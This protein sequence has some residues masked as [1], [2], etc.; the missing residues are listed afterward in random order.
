MTDAKIEGAYL[1]NP[2][3]KKA[4]VPIEYTKEQVEEYIKCANDCRYF[5]EEYV[6]IVHIDKGL[7]PFNMYPF[8]QKMVDAFTNER[9]VINKLPRQSGKSTTVTAYML[10]RVL[11][12]DNQN[13]AI[14]ANKGAL[15]RDLLSKVTMAYEHLPKWLQQGVLLWNRGNVELENGSKIVAAATSGSAIRGGSYNLIFLDEFAFVDNNLAEQFFASVYPT[16]SSGQTSQVI[17]V[18][19]PNGLN[20]FY[21][22]W[23]DA[24]EER[25]SYFPIEVQWQEVPGRDEKWKKETIANTSEEQFR[26]EFECE[27]IGSTNTLIAA[28]KL[29]TMAWHTPAEQHG[30][31]DIHK[32]PEHNHTYVVMVDT[33]RGL[34]LDYSASVVIDVSAMPYRVVAKFRHNNMSPLVYPST[35]ANIA[36]NYNDAFVLV[37]LNDIGQQVADILHFE[38][39]YENI[40][41]T[42]LHGR[43]GQQLGGGFGKQTQMGVKTT[44]QV[45]GIGCS[46]LKDLVEADKLIIEDFEIIGELASFVQRGSSYE[47]EPGQNDD[48]AMCLV[49][50]GWLANQAYFKEIT[51]IDIRQKIYNQKMEAMEDDILP[52]GIVEDGSEEVIVDNTGQRWTQADLPPQ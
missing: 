39:E 50:F 25:S 34:G 9:F 3:L 15:A 37:E 17:I 26:Q 11:F 52:F 41:A 47:A 33:S 45:K 16:I 49:L 44:K 19:T 5:I 8:Q 1:G 2:N 23:V 18:S 43:A 38:L 21:K 20:H 30:A 31:L 40:L 42:S 51:D 46:N 12:H 22:L 24:E 27:F 36:K 29:R 48:L 4:N 32:A 35:V 14:L 28:S 10:W 13:I 6:Q 7:V